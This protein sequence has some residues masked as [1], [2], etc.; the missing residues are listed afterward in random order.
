MLVREISILIIP[1]SGFLIV[2]PIVK[3]LNKPFISEWLCK[4]VTSFA[5]YFSK[6]SFQA[7]QVNSEV[8]KPVIFIWWYL[9]V[10]FYSVEL[11][12][13]ELED[14]NEL[15]SPLTP[16]CHLLKLDPHETNHFMVAIMDAFLKLQSSTPSNHMLAPVC[17]PG[18]MPSILTQKKNK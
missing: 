5:W 11:L 12:D 6:L 3:C 10:Y 2:W 18:K 8:N 15:E 17:L 13:L 7:S 9:L 14:H 16:S 1:F 4:D